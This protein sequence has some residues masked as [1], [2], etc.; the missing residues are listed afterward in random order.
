MVDA[1]DS[2]SSV[3]IRGGSSPLSGTHMNKEKISEYYDYTI[4]FYK[5][6][7]HGETRAIHYGVWYKE[8]KSHTEALLNTNKLIEEYG[9]LRD[10]MRVLDAGCGVGGTAFFLSRKYKISVDGITLS[11]KQVNKAKEL[12]D[13]YNLQNLDFSLQ[14]YSHTNFQDGTFD[15]IYGIE[16]IC[17][18]KD[19]KDFIKEA[20]RL[21]KPGGKLIIWD[22]FLEKPENQLTTQEFGWYKNFC[23][24]FAL[25]NLA[26][27]N[28]FSS[29]L[30]SIGFTNIQNID[31]T[32]NVLNTSRRMYLMSI[33]IGIPISFLTTLFKL[34]PKLL[35]LNNIT[36][37]DQFYLIQNKIMSLRLFVAEK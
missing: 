13:R 5:Y 14:D 22:G 37:R 12:K 23:D 32:I 33:F 30:K 11:L 7:W 15:L 24:G 6:F 20:H 18:E 19:K 28:V 10:G 26:E 25:L 35:Y 34:T 3:E 2:K 21:L 1:L 8:T 31:F 36:G 29:D 17:Y 16:S 9:C 4:N 27:Q